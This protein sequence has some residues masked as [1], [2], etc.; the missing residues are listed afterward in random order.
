ML[1]IHSTSYVIW[2][3]R[4]SRRQGYIWSLRLKFL[5][6]IHCE[7][8]TVYVTTCGWGKEEKSRLYIKGSKIF[9]LIIVLLLFINNVRI[10]LV[11]TSWFLKRMEHYSASTLRL[12]FL[13]SAPKTLCFQNK[14]FTE[15]ENQCSSFECWFREDILWTRSAMNAGI[16]SSWKMDVADW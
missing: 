7:L 1:G 3:S 12:S 4:Y 9:V 15:W 2:G 13:A 14:L 8:N 16:E 6:Q 11:F 10:Y 5:Y